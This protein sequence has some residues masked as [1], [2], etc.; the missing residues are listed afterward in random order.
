MYIHATKIQRTWKNYKYN[1]S[2]YF[3]IKNIKKLVNYCD[4]ISLNTIYDNNKIYNIE[5]LYPIIRNDKVYIYELISLKEL[6]KNSCVEIHTNSK[7]SKNE[8]DEIVF[9]TSKIKEDRKIKIKKKER[10]KLMKD[11]IFTVFNE[12]DT[13]FSLEIYEKVSKDQIEKILIELKMMWNAFKLDNKL[14]EIELFEK[15]LTWDDK[16][17]ENQLLTNI[18]IMIDNKIE[19]SFRKTISFVIIGAF[20]YINSEIKQAY[21]DIDFV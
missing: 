11:N 1:K 9:F 12:L 15:K 6:L 20:A 13:Y 2:M 10:F 4:V 18:Q 16:N 21:S 19:K 14:N 3:I 5:N 8:L 17:Y 7:L